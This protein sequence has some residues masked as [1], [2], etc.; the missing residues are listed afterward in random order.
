MS[1]KRKRSGPLLTGAVLAI[2][3]LLA[4]GWVYFDKIHIGSGSV[5][6]GTAFILAMLFQSFRKMI[7]SFI[8]D[9]L[10]LALCLFGLYVSIY[11][12]ASMISS[13]MID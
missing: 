12:V 1:G 8:G 6:L 7:L 13:I 5:F 9:I 11:I 10:L 4:M 2:G 3:Y